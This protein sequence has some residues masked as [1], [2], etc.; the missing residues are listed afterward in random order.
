MIVIFDGGFLV[1]VNLWEFLDLGL[2]VL[3]CGLVKLDVQG[4]LEWACYF[5]G[6]VFEIVEV[7]FG[8]GVFLKELDDGYFICGSILDWIIV[9][10]LDEVGMFLQGYQF[11]VGMID[12]YI[13]FCFGVYE[14]QVYINVWVF[15][16]LFM[17]YIILGFVYLVFDYEL[18][19][20]FWC[21]FYDG[22]VI[23]DMEVDEDGSI[24]IIVSGGF[25]EEGC[26]I[27]YQ[28]DGILDWSRVVGWIGSLF[29]EEFIVG[30]YYRIEGNEFLGGVSKIDKVIGDFI[31]GSVS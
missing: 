29:L 18:G 23:W 25:F 20:M 6:L 26:L 5:F 15:E 4:E 27:K 2:F 7:N 19:E 10:R 3:D 16:G 28:L 9:F 11:F 1:V 30:F 31:F 17:N 8:N 24:Y 14:S 22:V 12:W 13:V 21:D